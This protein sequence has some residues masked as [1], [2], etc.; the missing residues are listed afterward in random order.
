MV[1]DFLEHY[2]DVNVGVKFI[3]EKA[4]NFIVLS[5]YTKQGT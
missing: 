1:W 3:Q 5:E 4:Y 2:A